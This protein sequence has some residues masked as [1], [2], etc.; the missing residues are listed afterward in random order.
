MEKFIIVA[1]FN[2]LAENIKYGDDIF[3]IPDENK[4]FRRS[5]RTFAAR[6]QKTY[7]TYVYCKRL[8]PFAFCPFFYDQLAQ[9]F[10][11]IPYLCA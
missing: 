6:R 5:V 4:L 10:K 8:I 1:I 2:I 9:S 3:F 11:N 7:N